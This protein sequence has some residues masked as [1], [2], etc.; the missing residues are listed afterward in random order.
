MKRTDVTSLWGGLC[1]ATVLFVGVMTPTA[2]GAQDWRPAPA[3]QAQLQEMSVGFS[4]WLENHRPQAYYDIINGNDPRSVILADP[5]IS[6]AY[7]ADN[8]EPIFETVTNLD[9]AETISTDEV[10]PGGSS[11]YNLTGTGTTSAQLGIWEAG[12]NAAV[13]TTHQEFGGRVTQVDAV[14]LSNHA[15]HVAGTMVAAGI[16]ANAQGMSYQANLSAYD[17]NNDTAEMT[18]A[19]AAGLLVSNHS[20]GTICG[21]HTDGNWY[22][23]TSISQNEDWKFG[24]YNST[25]QQWDQL[26]V[27]APNYLVF[28]SAGNDRN[29]AA[30]AA[31]TSHLHGS[32]G[33]TFTDNH[34]S[35]F[36]PSGGYDTIPTSGCAKNIMT[37]GAVNDIAGGYSAVGDVVQSAFSGWGPT[38]DGRIKPDIV[39]NGVNLYSTGSLADN[40][41]DTMSGTS[42]STPSASGSANLLRGQF[43]TLNGAPP[44]SATLKAVIINGADEAGP[45][46]GPDYM[47][48]WGLMNTLTSADIIAA[49]PFDDAGIIE[50][51]LANGATDT[52]TLYVNASGNA[53]VT[54][55]WTDPAGTPP[56][57]SLDPNTVMLVNDLD[58]RIQHVPST[59]NYM[60]WVLNPASPANAAATGDNTLDNVEQIDIVGAPLGEYTITVSHKGTLSGSPQQYSLVYSGMSVNQAP[61]AICQSLILSADE[62]CLAYATAADIDDGS[63]D[64]DGDPITL[65]ISP[66]GPFALGN[67]EVVLTVEDDKGASS[68]CAATVTVVDDTP[69]MVSCPEDITVE[70]SAHG[71]VPKDDP[72]LVDFFASFSATDNCDPDPLIGDDA[73]DLFEGPCEASGGVT[74][75]TWTVQDASGNTAQCSA[76]VTVVDT[77]PPDLTVE[78]SPDVLWPPN[79]KMA[80]INATVTVTDTCDANPTFVLT[81][82][83]SDEPDNEV[84]VG[85]GNTVDDIQ[86]VSA[87]TDDVM[88]QL[89]SERQGGGDGRTYTVVYTATDCSGNTASDTS[90][91][92]VPHDQGGAAFAVSGFTSEA[93]LL[94]PAAGDFALMIPSWGQA[95]KVDPS[96][97]FVGNLDGAMAPLSHRWGDFNGDGKT[98]L[99][100]HYETTSALDLQYGDQPVASDGKVSKGAKKNIEVLAFRYETV[101]G[102][103]YLVDNIL[104]LPEEQM[105]SKDGDSDRKDLADGSEPGLS[106]NGSRVNLAI[107]E[108]GFVRVEVFS[109]LGRR[110]KTLVRQDMSAG[111]H[112]LA[113]NGVDDLGRSAPAGVYF[114]RVEAPGIREVKRVVR[115]Q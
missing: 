84:G 2:A 105:V 60:P 22:G 7:I 44:R 54:I 37:V 68:I 66:S 12:T 13:R 78:L 8:G 108:P 11:G 93:Q 17:S 16:M 63:Y 102:E 33:S 73:P 111:V 64:P 49:G 10:W 43:Q 25:A 30:P 106:V 107:S 56:A 80:D 27:N 51:D 112:E 38:D 58:L 99:V 29:D 47:N 86:G 90:Y 101:S 24:F 113:W 21:W 97:A 100:L 41:Y 18:A 3:T 50:D 9:A 114:Y 48:G 82:V 83:M 95:L 35:D 19:A 40:D 69:P 5:S 65:S 94:D 57:A 87:G 104:Q 46:P 26:A 91:V 28:K 110:V 14:G 115:I 52:Y 36:T 81:S 79:H 72:Q 77:T 70:C 75:V 88:F 98:D 103:A 45:A 4:Q 39:A 71:G 62:D 34:T 76:T 89:R 42:M 53:R 61:V 109:V 23:N 55:V 1:L 32:S 20:Y 6:L 59:T 96:R 85:D 67:T 92:L 74:V 15:T 31:G